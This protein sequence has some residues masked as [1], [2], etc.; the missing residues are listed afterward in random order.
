MSVQWP[1]YQPTEPGDYPAPGDRHQGDLAR[2]P[3]LEP[4]SRACGDVEPKAAGGGPIESEG[5]VDFGE[6][7]MGANL[8]RAITSILHE[9]CRGC[10]TGVEDQDVVRTDD[11]PGNHRPSPDIR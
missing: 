10:P 2:Y 6:M 4:D 11:L 8:N 9:N 3:W 5:V 1:G 7:E